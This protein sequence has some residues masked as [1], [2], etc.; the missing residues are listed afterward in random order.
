MG[1]AIERLAL[2]AGHH[3][4]LRAKA[5]PAPQELEAADVAVEFSRP[6]AAVANLEACFKAGVP[7]VSGTTGWLE[8]WDAVLAACAA[9]NGGFF[10]A[11]N[12]AVGVNIFFDLAKYI[13]Q[14]LDNHSDYIARIEEVHHIHKLD[15]PSGTAITLAEGVLAA[16]STKTAWELT[17]NPAPEVLGITAERTGEVVGTHR[18]VFE[19][20]IDSITLEHR[21]LTRDAFAAGALRAAAFM[22][23]KTGTYSMADLINH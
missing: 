17:P 15:A 4:V 2:A 13:Q 16:N 14:H 21:A 1:Q 12:F 11:S 6:D 7:V 10:Y 22:V 5:A 9:Q 20:N 3:V 8:Q 23:G 19:S 18:L